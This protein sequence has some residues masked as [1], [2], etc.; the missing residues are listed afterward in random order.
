MKPT[1]IAQI[2]RR[3]ERLPLRHQ[4]AHLS[5]LISIEQGGNLHKT[6]V[7]IREFQA[8]L[9]DVQVRRLKREGRAA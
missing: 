8:A 2:I 3:I 1:P 4:A 6:S 9:R 5:S 7:R